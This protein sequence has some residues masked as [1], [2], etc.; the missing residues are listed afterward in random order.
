MM[1]APVASNMHIER[2][3]P[4][5]PRPLKKWKH[6]QVHGIVIVLVWGRQYWPG[7]VRVLVCL[8]ERIKVF[9][10]IGI[11]LGAFVSTRGKNRYTEGKKGHCWHS[12]HDEQKFNYF[13]SRKRTCYF[14]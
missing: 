13:P 4:T 2:P 1:P 5:E 7:F 12:I 3:A 9:E 11:N 14:L 8:K 10:R 6:T